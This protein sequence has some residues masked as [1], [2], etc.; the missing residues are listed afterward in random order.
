MKHH[1]WPDREVSN[2]IIKGM[3]QYHKNN[4]VM[5]NTEHDFTNNCQE[6]MKDA[7]MNTKKA[8]K[9]NIADEIT[10]CRSGTRFAGDLWNNM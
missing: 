5:L 9:Q 4:L 1:G 7:L 3:V 2:L 8:A 6:I 10:H